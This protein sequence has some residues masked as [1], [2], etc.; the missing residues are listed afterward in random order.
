[1]TVFA[2]RAVHASGRVQKGHMNAAN[3]NELAFTLKQLDLELIQ[4]RQQRPSLAA[5]L[6]KRF[7]ARIDP[8]QRI[9][10][11][12]QMEDLLRAGV[13]FF[14]A[15]GVVVGMMPEGPLQTNLLSA[16][17]AIQAGG[18]ASES[19]AQ[20][21]LLFDP[22]FLA[23]LKA[24]EQS[25]DL[26][27]TFAR[28]A[29][30]LRWQ[31]KIRR[32]FSRALRYPL[33]LLSVAVCVTSFMMGF[34]VPEI[35]SFLTSLGT[36]LP[37]PT[38]LLIASASA[39]A[40]LWWLVPMLGLG[41]WGFFVFARHSSPALAARADGWLLNV[42][43]LGRVLRRLALARFATSFTLLSKS[44]LPLQTALAIGAETLGNRAL[45]AYAHEAARL[46]GEGRALSQATSALFP[47]F[48]QQMIRVGEKSGAMTKALDEVAKL[49]EREGQE[50][51]ETFLG[52][53]EPMLTLLVGGILAWIVLAVLGPVY[54]S[55]G[56]LARGI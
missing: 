22:V 36:E 13:P 56:P 52:A 49:Y 4:A 20:H 25:G 34:V 16:A 43:G 27:T 6:G 8:R 54:G 24:G 12:S 28:L 50:A 31:N 48:V 1:M 35:V 40:A 41:L 29:Q 45:S 10:L 44:G 15:L 32:A 3:E 7:Q 55:L 26:G 42:P 37:W 38:R 21:P 5:T 19:F 30:H 9:A 2:Y 47:P 17:Q 33:F 23:L 39:C 18:S 51:V 14:E 53:L 46:V 11:C